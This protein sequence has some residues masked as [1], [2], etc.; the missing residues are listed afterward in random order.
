LPP[1]DIEA[2]TTR[3]TARLP[4]LDIEIVH[5]RPSDNVERLSITL[6]VVPSF[7]AFGQFFETANPFAWWSRAAQMAWLPWLSFAQMMQTPWPGGAA[8]R[9]L[10]SPGASGL[11]GEGDAEGR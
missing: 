10:G 1:S 9:Q 4:G 8:P 11:S 7:E 5:Q 2:R 6:Q 3:A